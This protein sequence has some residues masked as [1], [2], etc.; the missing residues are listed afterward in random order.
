MDRFSPVPCTSRPCCDVWAAGVGH[1]SGMS[2]S[3]DL[4]SVRRPGLQTFHDLPV[5]G[6]EQAAGAPV[7]VT[8]TQLASILGIHSTTLRRMARSNQLPVRAISI[9]SRIRYSVRSVL[10]W[11]LEREPTEQDHEADCRLLTIAQSG[12]LL[13][14]SRATAYRLLGTASPPITPTP[15]GEE[16][17]FPACRVVAFVNSTS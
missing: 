9:D 13:G 4:D 6:R 11:L 3:T 1:S 15:V 5:N 10:R 7:V 8:S 14:C 2:T 17:R 16:T 12:V